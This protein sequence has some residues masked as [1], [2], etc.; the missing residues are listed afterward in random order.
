MKNHELVI[1]RVFFNESTFA[2]HVFYFYRSLAAAAVGIIRICL[3]ITV[4]RDIDGP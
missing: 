4:D 2:P 3:T 1:F